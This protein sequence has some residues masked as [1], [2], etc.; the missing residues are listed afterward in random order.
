MKK[1]SRAW[2]RGLAGGGTGQVAR[3]DEAGCYHDT[4]R[5]GFFS[6]LVATGEGFGLHAAERRDAHA[7]GNAE[8]RSPKR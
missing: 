3:A 4:A 8:R 1:Q 2:Q 5:Q 6:L 7:C